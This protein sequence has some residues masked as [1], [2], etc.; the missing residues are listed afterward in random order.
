MKRTTTPT[1][2]ARTRRPKGRATATLAAALIGL[3]TVAATPALA[4]RGD[5]VR[6]VLGGSFFPFARAI[7]PRASPR[8]RAMA[9]RMRAHRDDNILNPIDFRRLRSAGC[10]DVRPYD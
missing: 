1:P 6:T 3:G 7:G 9:D 4:D 5:A 10:Q 2:A 8:C